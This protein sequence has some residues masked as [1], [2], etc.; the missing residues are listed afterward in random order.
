M[1]VFIILYIIVWFILSALFYFFGN[2]SLNDPFSK[3]TILFM[4]S[5]MTMMVVFF[6]CVFYSP[7][8]RA[9]IKAEEDAKKKSESKDAEVYKEFWKDAINKQNRYYF[10]SFMILTLLPFFWFLFYISTNDIPII[11]AFLNESFSFL[12]LLISVFYTA[13]VLLLY[14]ACHEKI[15]MI[16]PFLLFGFFGG[17]LYVKRPIPFLT[18]LGFLALCIAESVMVFKKVAFVWCL[19][20]LFPFYLALFIMYTQQ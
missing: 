10:I 3:K 17:M 19:I 1:I 16:L 11:N 15:Y 2:V 20:P 6:L 18:T 5:H 14:T 4:I 13:M 8:N 7:L 9:L 12:L